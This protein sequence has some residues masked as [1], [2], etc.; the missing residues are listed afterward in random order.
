M[1]WKRMAPHVI[2]H[3]WCHPRFG[4]RRAVNPA[5]EAGSQDAYAEATSEEADSE[6]GGEE[7][8]EEGIVGGNQCGHGRC[9]ERGDSIFRRLVWIDWSFIYG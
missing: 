9:A 5:R 2:P 7:T 8:G 6:E 4:S 1:K 3:V